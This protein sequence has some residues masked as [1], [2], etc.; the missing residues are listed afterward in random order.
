MAM[1]NAQQ[2][3]VAKYTYDPFGN[4][5][6]KSGTLADA[7]TYRF[8]SQ[9]YHQPSGLSLYLY[10]AY[11]P[12]LQRWL[13]RDPIEELGGVNL[14][15]FVSNDPIRF[16]DPFGLL[17]F[18]TYDIGT[19]TLAVTDEDTGQT[20]VINAESG[21][22]PFGD[23]I[24]DGNF[25][26]LD[27]PKPDFFRLEPL[28]DHYGDDKDDKTGRNKFRLHRP[29]RTIGCIAAK[30]KAPWEKLRDMI[31]STKTTQVSVDSKSFNPFAPK[32]EIIK[33]FGEIRVIDTSKMPPIPGVPPKP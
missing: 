21:G 25:D 19:G 12:N 5:L 29:G 9:E 17:V 1:V 26:I 24:P 15:A 23:P 31:R 16:V 27:H 10:R 2:I 30:E 28:D 32:K 22:K 18:G 14:Y 7:N 8:S 3:V 33:K 4:T 20:I 6:S 11:D 13:N